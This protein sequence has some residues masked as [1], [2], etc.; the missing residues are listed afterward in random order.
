MLAASEGVEVPHIEALIAVVVEGEQALDLGHGGSLG[1]GCPATAIEQAVIAVLLQAPPQT[2]NAS[3]AA[4]QDLGRL[5]P[6]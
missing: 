6:T 1:R 5:D 4:A 3:R 2:P